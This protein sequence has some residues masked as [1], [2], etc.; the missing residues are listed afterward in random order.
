MPYAVHF[1]K[2]WKVRAY[3]VKI[4]SDNHLP[5]SRSEKVP[6][7]NVSVS[8]EKRVV[9]VIGIHILCKATLTCSFLRSL[10]PLRDQKCL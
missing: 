4:N 6:Q 7:D 10:L 9:W 1:G 2:Q 5:M 3:K 8:Q